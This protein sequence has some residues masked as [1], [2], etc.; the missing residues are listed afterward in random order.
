M[1]PAVASASAPAAASSSDE[2]V[3]V[4]E[5][6]GRSYIRADL[7]QQLVVPK[8]KADRAG[9]QKVRQELYGRHVDEEG[10]FQPGPP[11]K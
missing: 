10:N 5:Y 11:V 8:E 1:S 7:V 3:E 6:E 4:F 9:R 2:V